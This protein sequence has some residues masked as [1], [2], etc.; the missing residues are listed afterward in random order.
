MQKPPFKVAARTAENP[1]SGIREVFTLANE[2]AARGERVYKLMIGVP[3]A[4]TP[5]SVIDGTIAA[6][7]EQKTQYTANAGIPELR[8][9]IARQVNTANGLSVEAD[10][11]IVVP[12][13]MTGLLFANF[14]LDPG[15]RILIPT[16]G[17]PNYKMQA[18]LTGLEVV[19]YRLGIENGFQPDLDELD[20]LLGSDRTPVGA[21]LINTP[22]NPTGTVFSED[23]VVGIAT[24]AEKHGVRIISDEVYK[25]ILLDDELEHISPA[26]YAPELTLLVGALSKK[27]S[28]TGMRI[29]Y[30]ILPKHAINDTSFLGEAT[31]SCA[32]SVCQWGA[33]AALEGDQAQVDEYDAQYRKRRDAIVQILTAAG[34]NFTRPNGAFYLMADIGDA[35]M[36]SR[37]FALQL[38]D[39][40]G[41]GVAFGS[42]FGPNDPEHPLYAEC[43]RLVRIAFCSGSMEELSEGTKRLCQFYDEK[44]ALIA[45]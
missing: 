45:K 25:D 5:D 18:G 42:D 35:G 24:L 8:A 21:I 31:I 1:R 14:T 43:D 15:S 29:G 12:G 39:E 16:P 11:V 23:T 17:Y 3:D 33:L 30:L 20:D 34:I 40:K 9:A 7:R 41:V 27:Y 19:H 22:G 13:A 4:R 2:K 28:M 37:D 36:T 38:L 44:R 6:L 32:P 10:Q 26:R